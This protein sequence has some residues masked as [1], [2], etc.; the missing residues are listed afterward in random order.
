MK[1][2]P[3]RST[4][5]REALY[6]LAMAGKMPD[7]GVLDDIVRQYPAVLARTDGIRRGACSRLPSRGWG[8]GAGSR[9]H[10]GEPCGVPRHERVP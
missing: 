10:E 3:S 1:P 4:Q 8:G 6:A 5:R 2:I 7:A 9:S